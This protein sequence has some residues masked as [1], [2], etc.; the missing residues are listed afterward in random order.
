MS[1]P[2][3]DP[4][5]NLVQLD[6]SAFSRTDVEKIMALGEKQ[7]LLYR[8]FRCERKPAV[9]LDVYLVYSGARGKTPYASY[10]IERRRDGHYRLMHGR[11]GDQIARGRT[12]DDVLGQLPEDFFYSV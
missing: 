3:D 5:D 8:W 1:D 6:L 9:G 10:R 7:R 4:P 2:G 11:S 12:L